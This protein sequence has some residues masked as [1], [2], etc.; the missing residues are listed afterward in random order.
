MRI[1]I[2]RQIILTTLEINYNLHQNIIFS[3]L[4]SIYFFFFFRSYAAGKIKLFF[5][6]QPNLNYDSSCG[7]A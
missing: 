5:T 6:P 2:I 1:T 3:L 7:Y 4:K